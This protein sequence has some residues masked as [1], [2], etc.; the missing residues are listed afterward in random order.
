VVESGREALVER[1][2]ELEVVAELMR[3]ASEGRAMLA[4]I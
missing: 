4:T 2:A 1:E 3:D